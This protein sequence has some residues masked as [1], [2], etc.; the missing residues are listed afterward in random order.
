MARPVAGKARRGTATAGAP[1][2]ACQEPRC[3]RSLR[4]ALS[5]RAAGNTGR[6]LN[7][8]FAALLLLAPPAALAPPTA[9]A[10]VQQIAVLAPTT[11]TVAEG[12]AAEIAFC[13]DKPFGTSLVF[14]VRYG[15][16]SEGGASAADG[17]YD[18]AVTSVAFGAE[19]T[20]VIV[21]IPTGDD[22]LD[23]EDETFTV[24]FVPIGTLPDG[25][26]LEN[27]V[28][29]VTIEDDDS[30]PVLEAIAGRTAEVGETVEIVARATDADGDP[31]RY[32]WERRADEKPAQLDTTMDGTRLTFTAPAEGVYTLTV[33]ASDGRGN[34]DTEKVVITVRSPVTVSAP[35]AVRVTEATDASAT[36]RIGMEKAFGQAVTFDVRYG[37]AGTDPAAAGADYDAVTS[38]VFGA[39]ATSAALVVP[40]TDDGLDEND[41][42]FTV[43]VSPAGTLPA[44]FVLGNARTTVTIVDDDSSP[45]LEAIED[46]TVEAGVPVVVTARA[47]DADDGDLIGYAWT[48]RA[49]ETPALPEDVRL[50]AAQLVFTPPAEGLYTLTVTAS[51]GHGNF[52]TEEVVITAVVPRGVTVTPTALQVEEGGASSYTLVLDTRP[53]AAVTVAVSASAGDV[54]AEP[55]ALTF[56]PSDWSTPQTVTVRAGEDDDAVTDADVTLNHGPSGGGYDSVSVDPVTVSVVDTDTAGVTVTPTSLQV[57]EGGAVTYTVVLDTQPLAAVTVTASSDSGSVKPS[58]SSLVFTSSDWLTPQT[59][60]VEAAKDSDLNDETVT[61]GHSASGADYGSVSVDPVTVTV[62]DRTLAERMGRANRS[63]L[64]QV[65]AAIESES[66]DAVT[67][68]IE[69]AAAGHAPSG[70]S[71]GGTS[72]SSPVGS[73][74]GIRGRGGR[75]P[76]GLG[77]G[78]LPGSRTTAGAGGLSSAHGPSA[79]HPAAGRHP[80]VPHLVDPLNGAAFTLPIGASEDNGGNGLGAA[81]S[82]LT[83]WGRGGSLSLS[84]SDRGVSWAGDLWSGH[85]GADMRVGRGLLVGASV[86]HYQVDLDADVVDEVDGAAM[87]SFGHDTEL[88]LLRPYVAWLSPGGAS[89]WASGSYG[90]GELRIGEQEGT[91]RRV[92]MSLMSMAVGGGGVL[93]ASPDLIAGGVTRLALRGEGS[94]V[95]AQSDAGDDLAELRVDTRRLRLALEGSHE[96]TLTGG[97]TLTP[98]L[99]L[100]L[101]HDGG[102][103]LTGAGV[104]AGA[105]LV[106][107]AP[108]SGLSIEL[109]SRALLAHERDR[110]EWGVGALVRLDPGLEGEGLF[111]TLAPS[112]GATLSGIGQMFTRTPM[113]PSLA[114]AGA[115]PQA[116]RLET[117]IGHGF[118]LAGPGQTA[119][120]APYAGLTTVERAERQWR[121]GARYRLREG[122]DFGLE[123][124]RRERPAA[125]TDSSLTLQGRLVW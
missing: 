58:P 125:P 72:P 100:G 86:S 60:T 40:I 59:V 56:T 19:D 1:G 68:R 29:T 101:R 95:L 118:L 6:G 20:S 49:G 121:L 35:E 2:S 34:S 4:P 108:S 83:L 50:D 37:A 120:L 46:M 70:V 48:R 109:R 25:F 80:G 75:G 123:L 17:D 28:T 33:T 62:T 112:T 89:V 99:E 61:V 124:E 102:D 78:A 51:D 12:S 32:F 63:L 13:T 119:L 45:V 14:E 117:E 94:L 76:R 104:E 43:T 41:E 81:R 84:G 8:A 113:S 79:P 115:G 116:G 111:L 54:T 122:I 31:I 38:V 5:P 85:L 92:D 106:W 47:S 11:V 65:A 52:D 93:H 9:D 87:S 91:Q 66:L 53:T 77:F 10:Q 96:R 64:P 15:V 42:T 22:D 39:E 57:L 7:G 24:T 21:T 27:M 30:S 90:Q 103:V 23:E 71:L 69:A 114:L 36:V 107:R 105:S 98:A 55:S 16:P 26:V 67:S 110:E 97:G 74:L 18:D 82:P 88:T 44:G 73:G 3:S